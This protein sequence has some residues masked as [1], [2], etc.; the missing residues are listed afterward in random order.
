MIA[1]KLTKFILRLISGR[2]LQMNGIESLEPTETNSACQFI[3]MTLAKVERVYVKVMCINNVELMEELVSDP[4]IIRYT[5]TNVE[6]ANV[7]FLSAIGFKQGIELFGM[8]FT[9]IY[10]Q[11]NK[12]QVKFEW[13]GFEDIYGIDHYEYRFL[14][15]TKTE[16]TWKRVKKHTM[17][18][19]DGLHL[20]P[21]EI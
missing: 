21:N 11:L 5:S 8:K 16:G 17:Y 9:E 10:L 19:L 14:H 18:E 4:I 3:N 2:G 13:D 6:F 15:N 20:L 12:S 1:M 7:Q